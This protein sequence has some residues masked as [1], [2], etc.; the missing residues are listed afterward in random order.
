MRG[1][2]SICL[3]VTLLVL[4][5][6]VQ[7]SRKKSGENGDEKPLLERN[8]E[9]HVVLLNDDGE[10]E[11]EETEQRES[12]D[13]VSDEYIDKM[14]HSNS[15]SETKPTSYGSFE[16]FVSERK[17]STVLDPKAEA[18]YQSAMEILSKRRWADIGSRDIRSAYM[19]LEEAAQ[20]NHVDAEK[21]LAFSYLFGDYRWSI[22]EAKQIFEKLAAKGSADG[23]LGLGFLYSTGVG[24]GEPNPAKGFLHYTFS[25]LGG[26]PLAQMALGYRYGYGIS[27]TQSC[28]TSLMWYRKVAEKVVS[29][30]KLTGTASIQRIRIP[31]EIEASSTSSG[32]LLD[33]NVFSYYKYLAETGDMQA[34]LGLAQLYLTGGKGVPLDLEAAAKYFTIAAEA[35]NTQAFGFLGKMYLE[36]TSA[37]QQNNV[38][39]FQYFKKAADKG[40]AVGQSGLGMMFLYGYG[41]KADPYKALKL[42]TLAAEQGLADAQLHL[43]QM[44]YKGQ[45]VKRDFKQALKYFQLASQS[46]HILAVYNLA[47][48]HSKGIGVLRNC[49][50]AMALYKNVA[51]RGRWAERFMDAYLKFQSG[52]VDEAAFRYLFLAE[53]GYEAA[54]TNFAYIMDQEE[55][56]LFPQEEAYQRALLSW[57]RA[58][59]QDYP[60]ARVKL[61]D[62]KYYGFGTEVDLA[63]AANHYKIAATS[64]QSAQAMFN[65]GYMH[66]HGLGVN[67]DLHLAKRYYD[68]AAETSTEA[69][70]PVALALVKLRIEF[71]VEHMMAGV[72]LR[73]VP[74]VNFL[75]IALGPNWD[76]YVMSLLLGLIVWIG[77][78][79]LRNRN[80][81][82]VQP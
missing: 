26:N 33:N 63:E 79:F 52:A 64:H 23:H 27:T 73:N 14:Q 41:M 58:A 38:T 34:I 80:R 69:F 45:G 17:T 46:G 57:Q 2:Y 24:I 43:G 62:Y 54:Q 42:F 20:L 31:D 74:A 44:Y 65:L 13:D 51:E 39:A 71:F 56:R 60:V 29:K 59:N 78:C 3:I 81:A 21:I 8:A 40:N 25:A 61:G 28:E 12:L 18:L 76:L 72:A 36:G 75:D 66:E 1:R 10:I 70:V 67:K 53:F 49:R 11:T 32:T 22:D 15:D 55:T 19:D 77:Y 4:F 35:G 7:S 9:E 5:H 50:F 37:T 47:Q 48:M 30:V 82:N 16:E 6:H 68:L